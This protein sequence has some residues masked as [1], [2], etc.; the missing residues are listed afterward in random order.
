MLTALQCLA[1]AD[2]M[3]ALALACTVPGGRVSYT[4]TAV[5]WRKAAILAREQEAWAGRQG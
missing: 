5:H 2:E 3:D 4:E 1:K